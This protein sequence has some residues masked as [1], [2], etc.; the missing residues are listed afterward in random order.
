MKKT[1]P[2]PG[3]NPLHRIGVQLPPAKSVPIGTVCM[4]RNDGSVWVADGDTSY[5]LCDLCE[6]LSQLR[7]P[8]MEWIVRWSAAGEDPL[9]AA[10][11]AGI[12]V[13]NR[14]FISQWVA[15]ENVQYTGGWLTL[16]PEGIH[17]PPSSVLCLK[18]TKGCPTMAEVLDE[19]ARRQGKVQSRSAG[20]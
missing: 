13:S 11:G 17:V 1:E 7:P 16:S 15:G 2:G 19:L 14:L 4:N 3:S 18:G 20:T 10:W 8:P 9:R 5:P 12:D 6:S